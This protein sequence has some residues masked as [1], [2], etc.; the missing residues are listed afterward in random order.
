M[1]LA[2]DRDLLV[3]PPSLTPVDPDELLASMC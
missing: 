1:S 3:P 2:T